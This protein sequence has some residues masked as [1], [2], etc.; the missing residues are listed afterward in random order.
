MF[1][2]WTAYA[3][4]VVSHSRELHDAAATPRRT[5]HRQSPARPSVVSLRRHA[6][7]PATTGC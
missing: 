4:T 3:V 1:T 7:R 6:A 2:P 5:R